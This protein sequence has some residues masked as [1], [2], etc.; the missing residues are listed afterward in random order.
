ME[1]LLILKPIAQAFTHSPTTENRIAERIDYPPDGG[2]Q[3][4]YQ[5]H[6]YPEKIFPFPEAFYCLDSVKR[7]IM[8]SLRVVRHSWIMSFGLLW[9][10]VWPF[11]S[12]LFSIILE[13]FFEFSNHTLS[14]IAI[15]PNFYC[16][17]G[18]EIHRAGME[19]IVQLTNNDEDRNQGQRI[20]NTICLIWEFDNAYRYRGQDLMASVDPK[21]M[22][23]HPVRALK[24]LCAVAGARD[25][26][27]RDKFKMISVGLTILMLNRQVRNVVKVF[28]LYVDI[29]KLYLDAGD[30]YWCY[31]FAEYNFDNLDLEG[32]VTFRQMLYQAMMQDGKE[33]HPRITG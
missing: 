15:K 11:K 28:F 26:F 23:A 19:T 6:P 27:L 29:E 17:S 9:I 16:P 22:T 30:R 13:Q 12:R 31:H 2:M 18:R 25:S 10:C 24:K 8:N 14:K 3:V 21:E 7:A 32:R 33:L 1:N 20:L 4:F 5:G